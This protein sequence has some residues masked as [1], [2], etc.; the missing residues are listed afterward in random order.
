MRSFLFGWLLG[1]TLA[2]IGATIGSALLFLAARSA[3]GHFLRDRVGGFSARL[4]DGFRQDAFVYLLVLRLAPFIPFVL[5][6]IAPAL[7][8]VKLRTFIGATAIGIIPAVFAYAWLGQ[9]LD[10]VLVAASDAGRA[11][12]VSD[13]VTPEITIAFAALALV[14][15]LAAIVRKVWASR[16]T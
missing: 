9:G 10:S 16:S 11:V 5:V 1:G 3:F 6:N 8:G 2:L 4:A 15:I 14:A 13:L 12:A 7:F